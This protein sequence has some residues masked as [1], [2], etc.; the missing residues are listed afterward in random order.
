[1]WELAEKIL[2]VV[3]MKHQKVNTL[4][5]KDNSNAGKIFIA[6]SIYDAFKSKCIITNSASAGFAWEKA[7]DRR[8]IL[9][10]ETM[11]ATNQTE[12]YKLIMGGADCMVN[13]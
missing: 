6:R 9:N 3:D 4:L 11:I 13:H 2:D 5:F 12:E 10:E 7:I 1:M 8:I